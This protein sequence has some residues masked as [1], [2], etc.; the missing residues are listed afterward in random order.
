MFAQ[1]S[2]RYE[3]GLG[4]P[5][6]VGLLDKEGLKA[7]VVTSSESVFHA[8]GF[9]TLPT[10]G[11]PIL[12]SLRNVFP[13]SVVIAGA[14]NRHHLCWSFSPQ[15]VNVDAQEVVFNDRAQTVRGRHRSNPYKEVTR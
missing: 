12:Y 6:F 15:N 11:N 13:Y 10:S 1:H 2:E 14:G 5:R 3:P 4:Q 9:P 7:L 8:I